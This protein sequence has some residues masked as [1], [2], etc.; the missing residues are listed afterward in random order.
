MLVFRQLFD[1]TSSTYTYLL[2]CSATREA[3]LIDPVFEQVRRDAALIG[4]HLFVGLFTSAAYSRS[5]REIPILRRKVEACV[6]RAGFDP[7]SHDGKALLHILEGFPRDELFQMS[8]DELFETALGILHLQERQR[9]ALFTRRDPFERF[10]SCLV[11]LPRDRLTTELR[12]RMQHILAEAYHG[13]LGAF[14]T[15]VTDDKLARLHIVIET[16]PNAIP[17]VDQAELEARLV[18]VGRSWTDYLQEALIEAHGEEHGL[19][20]VALEL[21]PAEVREPENVPVAVPLGTRSVT[22]PHR[23][24]LVPVPKRVEDMAVVTAETMRARAA[25]E[26]ARAWVA[27]E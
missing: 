18:E 13:K 24:G 11:F 14:Y 23:R 21:A 16:T 4:E 10:I 6:E 26:A 5:P 3:L 15:Q 8:A 9:I 2:G 19:V 7:A 27:A 17:D 1:P 22:A 25:K 20:P 12:R